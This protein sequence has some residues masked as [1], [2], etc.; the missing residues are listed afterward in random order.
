MALSMEAK[1][2]VLADNLSKLLK[3]NGEGEE[4]RFTYLADLAHLFAD[5]VRG[6][7]ANGSAFV[8]ALS[9]AAQAYFPLLH[10]N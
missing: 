6:A 2:A 5:R 10:Q 9:D 8:S 3:Q 7:L 4:L 1:A